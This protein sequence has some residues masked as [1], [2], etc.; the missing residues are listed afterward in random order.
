MT[1]LGHRVRKTPLG[2]KDSNKQGHKT[3]DFRGDPT[4][5]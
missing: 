4:H 5:F 1:V 3:K 2:L